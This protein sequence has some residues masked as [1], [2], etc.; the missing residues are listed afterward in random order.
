MTLELGGEGELAEL[1]TDH[2]FRDV[3]CWKF[4]SVVDSEG[5]TDELWRDI[6]I[7]SPGLDDL[8]LLLFDHL[9]DLPKE[10]RINVGAFFERA[11]HGGEK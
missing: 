8:L 5:E 6:A 4:F 9:H 1:V 2:L 3:D 11:S 10:L 7:A